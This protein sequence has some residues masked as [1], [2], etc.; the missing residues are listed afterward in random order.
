MERK[1]TEITVQYIY[2][3]YVVVIC[4]F[5][6]LISPLCVWISE[7]ETYFRPF[8]IGSSSSSTPSLWRILRHLPLFRFS[9]ILFFFS[10][11]SPNVMTSRGRRTE[12]PRNPWNI[13]GTPATATAIAEAEKEVIRR[14]SV[15]TSL[16]RTWGRSQQ[17]GN[18]LSIVPISI[19]TDRRRH[20]NSTL[21]R[22]LP[23]W[24]RRRQRQ[25]RRA[26]AAHL[27]SC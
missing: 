16:P 13:I 1:N 20:V 21:L 24:R 27:R 17:T 12:S 4:H 19:I 9:L 5:R 6:C 11:V 23:Q 3:R 14:R 22:E 2:E 25:R 15:Y 26:V 8:F 10:A 18:A 7:L